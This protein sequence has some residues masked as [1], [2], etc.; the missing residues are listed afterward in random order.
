LEVKRGGVGLSLGVAPAGIILDR[1]ANAHDLGA[2]IAESAVES[3]DHAL[4]E[5]E[6]AAREDEADGGIV[7]EFRELLARSHRPLLV[8]YSAASAVNQSRGHSRGL[9]RDRAS[10]RWDRVSRRGSGPR[11][12][13]KGFDFFDEFDFS[14]AEVADESI[15]QHERRFVGHF[16]WCFCRGRLIPWF[17]V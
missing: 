13:W 5:G 1:R 15:G 6:R 11:R 14:A 3:L 17:L 7:D 9:R 16:D 2:A 10:G 12:G 4:L 8:P